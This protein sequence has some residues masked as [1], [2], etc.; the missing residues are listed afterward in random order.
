M[1]LKSKF[2][3]GVISILF[4]LTVFLTFQKFYV[5]RSYLVYITIPC[6]IYEESCF[7]KENNIYKKA[8]FLAK[9][10]ATCDENISLCPFEKVILC[11]NQNTES[12]EV[13]VKK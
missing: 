6:N 13:C 9:N 12:G 4:I 3:F 8:Y 7:V 1:D 10:L 5:S 11:D 2:L